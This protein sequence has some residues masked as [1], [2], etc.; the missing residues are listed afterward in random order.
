MIET[1]RILEIWDKSPRFPRIPE[2]LKEMVRFSFQKKD[3]SRPDSSLLSYLQENKQRLIPVFETPLYSLKLSGLAPKAFLKKAGIENVRNLLLIIWVHDIEFTAPY[4]RIDH[5]KWHRQNFTAALLARKISTIFPGLNPEQVFLQTYLQDISLYMLSRTVPELYDS[6]AKIHGSIRYQPADDQKFV[7]DHHGHL[8]ARIL[9]QW[10]FPEEFIRPVEKHHFPEHNG[11][12]ENESLIPAVMFFSHLAAKLILNYGRH[13]KYD[14]LENVF[15]RWFNLSSDKLQQIVVEVI[16]LLPRLAQ[17]LGFS[18]LADLSL[19]HLIEQNRDFVAKRLFSYEELLEEIL[20]AD[21]HIKIL[22]RE[23]TELK[24]QIDNSKFKDPQ[25]GFYNHTYLQEVLSRRLQESA[26]YGYPLSFIL[27]D[28]DSFD[29][30]NKSYGYKTGNT[31]LA[32]MSEIVRKHIRESDIVAR[33]ENDEFAIILPHTGLPQSRFVG[34]KLCRLIAGYNFFDSQ[35]DR[36]HRLTVSVGCTTLMP[37]TSLFQKEKLIRQTR[38]V[39]GRSKAA[40]GNCCT[41]GIY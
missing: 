4:E 38:A 6:L 40:G 12:E 31:I 14:Y 9:R 36:Q 22:D 17:P 10:G 5:P 21:R 30:F 8:T 20:K 37:E 26:R 29:L 25:T 3:H 35:K 41:C 2:P 28:I 15:I 32:Q 16:R 39:L 34:E 33:L 7:E 24:Q 23:L 13:I 19:V 11:L 18:D 27:F 1:E